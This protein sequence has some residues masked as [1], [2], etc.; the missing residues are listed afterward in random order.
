MI[1]PDAVIKTVELNVRN[2][3]SNLTKVQIGQDQYRKDDMNDHQENTLKE[4]C[5]ERG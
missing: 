5:H 1:N 2:R 4:G 3:F